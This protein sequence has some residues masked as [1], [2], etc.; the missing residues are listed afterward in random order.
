MLFSYLLADVEQRTESNNHM[1]NHDKVDLT[2]SVSE[3]SQCTL[4]SLI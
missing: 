1:H 4:S 3:V 2:E